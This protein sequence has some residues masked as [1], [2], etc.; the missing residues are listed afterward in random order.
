MALTVII[1]VYHSFVVRPTE[2]LKMSP[3]LQEDSVIDVESLKDEPT[4]QDGTENFDFID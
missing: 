2:K 4:E 3:I 1:W